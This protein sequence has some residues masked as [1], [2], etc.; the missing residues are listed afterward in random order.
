MSSSYHSI[1]KKLKFAG[2]LEEELEKR[3]QG[4]WNASE[5]TERKVSECGRI[6][7]Q[8][9][10]VDEKKIG[11]LSVSVQNFDGTDRVQTMMYAG[12][13]PEY[14]DENLLLVATESAFD[15]LTDFADNRNKDGQWPVYRQDGHSIKMADFELDGSKR[16]K[17]K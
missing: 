16:K 7:S 5:S 11:D 2:G 9:I 4:R 12:K 3:F 14:S 1:M 10:F 8:E 15:T 13:I 17:L 6:I